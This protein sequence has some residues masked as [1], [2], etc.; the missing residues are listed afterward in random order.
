MGG[1]AW[2]TEN[3][4]FNTFITNEIYAGFIVPAK[5]MF[6][7]AGLVCIFAL[8]PLYFLIRKGFDINENKNTAK[9]I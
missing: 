1:I 9:V 3:M 4:Y 7:R 2:N 6:L 5:D 8:I